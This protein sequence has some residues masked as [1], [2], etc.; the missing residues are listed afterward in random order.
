MGKADRKSSKGSSSNK[1]QDRSS[2]ERK[3]KKKKKHDNRPVPETH[4]VRFEGRIDRDDRQV[5]SVIAGK[6][7]FIN[8]VIYYCIF[9]FQFAF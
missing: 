4:D 7:S 2:R 9:H 8:N 5:S 1:G 6:R 3:G